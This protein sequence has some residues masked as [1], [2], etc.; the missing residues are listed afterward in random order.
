D[1]FLKGD[2][3]YI[4]MAGHHQIWTLDL[5][6]GVVAPFAGNGFEAISDGPPGR[7]SFAQPSGLAGD[8]Q[9]LYVADSEARAI[10]SVPLDG[11]GRVKTVVGV[12]G[13]DLFQF[14][15]EDGVGEKVR[16]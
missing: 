14:G 8:G 9:T 6:E 13:A 2:T 16:L 7:A 11:K 12:E 4:A 5:A 15:D 1:L 10:R 3:L